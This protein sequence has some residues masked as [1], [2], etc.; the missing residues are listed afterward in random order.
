MGEIDVQMNYGDVEEMQQIFAD[1]ASQLEDLNSQVQSWAATLRDGALLGEAGEALAHAFD[2]VLN[3]KV[4]ALTEKLQELEGDMAG[5]LAYF[6]DG[7]QDA[8]SRFI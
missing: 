1:S 7:E 2:T 8:K 5:T 3:A 6:R 4:V